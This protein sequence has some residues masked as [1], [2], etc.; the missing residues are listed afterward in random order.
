M[1]TISKISMV[2][3]FFAASLFVAPTAFADDWNRKTEVTFSQPIEVPG[4]DPQVLPAGT[5][6]F[7]VMDSLSDRHIVQIFNKEMTHVY[8]TIIAI[9]NYRMHA[10]DKTVMTF[11]ERAAGEAPAIR[12]WFYPGR[13]W[14]EEFVYPKSKAVI[15]AKVV[16]EPVLYTPI[17]NPTV[18][19][20]R[21]AP[22]VAVQPTGEDV[23]V[24]QVVQAPPAAAAAVPPVADTQEAKTLPQT[25]SNLPLFALLGL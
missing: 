9:P 11:R 3:C 4:T 7:K 23:P 16:N 13:E 8:T 19:T 14:G 5:Y 18:E 6:I 20:L 10:T 24:A 17:E 12:A 2:L 25:G 21:T 22:I 1:K 15:L